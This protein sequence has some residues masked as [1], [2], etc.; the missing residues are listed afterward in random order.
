MVSVR[1]EITLMGKL[2]L[3]LQVTLAML[4]WKHLNNERLRRLEASPTATQ[5]TTAMIGQSGRL[6]FDPTVG[7]TVGAISRPVASEPGAKPDSVAPVLEVGGNLALYSK[8]RN[9]ERQ[10]EPSRI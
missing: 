5:A 3:R 4:R 2:I 10:S 8:F 6:Q 9:A 7:A 1:K